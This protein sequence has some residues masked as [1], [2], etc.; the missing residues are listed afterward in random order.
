MEAEVDTINEDAEKALALVDDDF[1]HLA[2]QKALA[3][4]DVEDAT[5]LLE[6]LPHPLTPPSKQRV[7]IVTDSLG[8]SSFHSP[9]KTCEDVDMQRVI[10]IDA[11]VPQ[12]ANALRNLFC[13][14]AEKARTLQDLRIYARLDS[15]LHREQSLFCSRVIALLDHGVPATYLKAY[16]DSDKCTEQYR[17]IWRMFPNS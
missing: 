3:T 16:L 14:T 8:S 15:R 17:E 11:L 1:A 4:F 12:A 2:T 9:A 10:A 7:G 13:L 5:R 6:E